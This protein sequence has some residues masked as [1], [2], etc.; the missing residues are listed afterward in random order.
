M[1]TELRLTKLEKIMQ[2]IQT[3][4]HTLTDHIDRHYAEQTHLRN[5][6][7]RDQQRITD[8]LES[9]AKQLHAQ[10][11]QFVDLH[12]REDR[13]TAQI[14]R[15]FYEK[16]RISTALLEVI[17]E[18]VV[19]EV[20]P[21]SHFDLTT[22]LRERLDTPPTPSDTPDHPPS[23]DITQTH[24]TPMTDEPAMENS[25]QRNDEKK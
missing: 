15:G 9:Q 7:E 24:P 17:G 23:T 22:K 4:Q 12:H 18:F 16:Q 14:H 20:K 21:G 1:Q 2:T 5:R 10:S 6:Y 13:L 8:I 3:A 19:S 25:P 11:Q